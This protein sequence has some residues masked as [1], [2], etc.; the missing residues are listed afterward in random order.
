MPPTKP[1]TTQ[2]QTTKADEP[3]V[4]LRHTRSAS[5]WTRQDAYGDQIV[6]A[7]YPARNS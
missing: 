6:V 3:R 5:T 1:E 4:S 2:D 7:C